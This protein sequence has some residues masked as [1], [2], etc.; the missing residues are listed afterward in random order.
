MVCSSASDE[1]YLIVHG[2][3]IRPPNG[4]VNDLFAD[5]FGP[6]PAYGIGLALMAI[7]LFILLRLPFPIIG[8]M[9]ALAG[10]IR[11]TAR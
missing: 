4:S 9:K 11:A 6:S 2:K 8:W 3:A 10:K 7:A 5:V 1:R